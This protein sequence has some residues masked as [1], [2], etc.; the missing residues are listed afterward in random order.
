MSLLDKPESIEE[1]DAVKYHDS[2]GSGGLLPEFTDFV[3]PR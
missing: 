3:G 1:R 2:K